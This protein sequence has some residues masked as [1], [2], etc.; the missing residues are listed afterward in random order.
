[1][2]RRM[3][4]CMYFI[5]LSSQIHQRKQFIKVQR[6]NNRHAEGL[7][8][9]MALM[10]AL[11]WYNTCTMY[12]TCTEKLMGSQT[13]VTKLTLDFINSLHYR[14]YELSTWLLDQ[15]HVMEQIVSSLHSQ[16]ETKCRFHGERQRTETTAINN[17]RQRQNRPTIRLTSCVWLPSSS[18]VSEYG[19]HGV[20]Q[21]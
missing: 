19:R 14:C 9:Q 21:Q 18:S 5:F 11:T 15:Q 8:G 3:Y 2:T 16:S 6:G 7:R 17:S 13:T 20:S 1:M 12:L 10:V 4:V